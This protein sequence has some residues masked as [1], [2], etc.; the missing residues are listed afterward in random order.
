MTPLASSDDESLETLKKVITTKETEEER[1][2][3][4]YQ[5]GTVNKE[6]LQQRIEK[7]RKEQE[8]IR[9]NLEALKKRSQVAIRLKTLQELSLELT[10]DIDSFDYERKRRILKLLLWGQPGI[11]VFLNH[12]HSVDLKGLVDFERLKESRFSGIE[13]TTSC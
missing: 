3:D 6:K 8:A 12:D 10:E 9:Q 5:I 2:L 7:L 4:L 1:L 13:N 11:G